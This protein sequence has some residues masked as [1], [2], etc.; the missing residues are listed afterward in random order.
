MGNR[1]LG[2]P[3]AM[4]IFSL[5]TAI[6]TIGGT[7]GVHAYMGKENAKELKEVKMC[8]SVLKED[9]S[10]LKNENEYQNKTINT[11]TKYVEKDHEW[12]IKDA[13][14]K[15]MMSEITKSNLYYGKAE[16]VKKLMDLSN[17]NKNTI[18]KKELNN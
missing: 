3:R 13:E 2:I 1:F 18:L 17:E 14:W 11:L 4:A 15:G 16:N 7:W 9:V 6:F 10:T 5:F 12:K 8:Q